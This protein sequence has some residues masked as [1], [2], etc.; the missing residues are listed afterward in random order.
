MPDLT[1]E[2]EVMLRLAREATP[3]PWEKLEVPIKGSH[4]RMPVGVVSV[5]AQGPVFDRAMNFGAPDMYFI[6]AANPEAVTRLCKRL[7]A[8]ERVA[9]AASKSLVWRRMP[10]N[11]VGLDDSIRELQKALSCLDRDAGSEGK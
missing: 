3:G 6:V 7:I 1:K 11:H 8:L 4:F 2:A 9:E 5:T 10:L